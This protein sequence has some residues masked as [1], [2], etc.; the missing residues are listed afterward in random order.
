VGQQEPDIELLV[1]RVERAMRAYAICKERLDAVQETLGRY[2]Q[3]KDGMPVPPAA[4]GV[5]RRPSRDGGRRDVDG[6][7]EEDISF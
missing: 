5:P 7:D 3:P 1:R 6:Q 4:S 2:L